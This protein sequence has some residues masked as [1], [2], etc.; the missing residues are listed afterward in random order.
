[1]TGRVKGAVAIVTGAAR[2]IGAATARLLAEQGAFV[3]ILDLLEEEGRSVADEVGGLYINHDISSCEDWRDT[4]AKV[5]AKYGRID[6]LAN[7][8]SIEGDMERASLESISISNFNRVMEVNAGGMLLGCQSV[9]PIMKEQKKG[10]IINFSSVFATVGSPYSLAYGA[11]KAAIEQ[12][13]RS[14]ALEGSRGELCIRCNSIQP[15][16][17]RTPMLESFF[18]EFSSAFNVSEERVEEVAVKPIPLG[19]IG[20]SKDV[21][22]LVLFLASD[23]SSYMTG[24]EIQIDGGWHLTEGKYDEL[25]QS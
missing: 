24:T 18:A 19:T 2:G 25:M 5:L 23:E 4:T 6:I 8:A 22:N 16:L 20:K 12:L 17:I 9:F 11:S 1:M 3:I 21:A 13:S 14:I 10:S 15:G 7:V